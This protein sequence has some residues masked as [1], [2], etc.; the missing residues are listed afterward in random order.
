MSHRL[1]RGLS[2]RLVVGL[3]VLAFPLL[4]S[5]AAQAA[6]AG[7]TPAQFTGVPNLRSAT[8]NF[9]GVSNAVQV[10]FDKTIRTAS[11]TTG[12]RL[13]GYRAGNLVD[14]IHVL[15]G[16]EQRRTARSCSSR[17]G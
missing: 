1:K 4:V 3:S 15:A 9:D 13:G 10:C 2:S 17:P 5:G 12:F 6:L 8:I 7:A 16:S 14:S 11:G